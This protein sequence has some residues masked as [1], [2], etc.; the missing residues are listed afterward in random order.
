VRGP[1]AIPFLKQTGV[2]IGLA[3]STFPWPLATALFLTLAMAALRMTA[4][5]AGQQN[6]TPVKPVAAMEP[7]LARPMLTFSVVQGV[8]TGVMGLAL[9]AWSHGR[10]PGLSLAAVMSAHFFGMFGLVPV[11]VY[12]MS[13]QRTV[14]A[15]AL[16]CLVTA[17]STLALIPAGAPVPRGVGMFGVGLGWSIAYLAISIRL[18]AAQDD[19]QRRA[20]QGRND[21]LGQLVGGAV[22][23]A[24]GP[25]LGGIGFTGLL[26]VLAAAAVVAMLGAATIPPGPR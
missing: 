9:V 1:I 6:P 19:R 24:A 4:L 26:I 23:L 14:A 25:I 18:A 2:E 10:V 21:L 5:D 3:L 20:L 11:L 22:P 13:P 17:V 12:R 15:L 16:A 7:G 8:M